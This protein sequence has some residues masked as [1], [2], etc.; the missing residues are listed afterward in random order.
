M[1]KAYES[2]PWPVY[3]KLFKVHSKERIMK[4][5]LF[6]QKYER[7]LNKAE[8]DYGVP[9]ELIVAIIGIETRYGE[10]MGKYRVIDSLATLAFDYPKR[11]H[12]FRS[13]LIEFLLLVNEQHFDAKNVY[14]SRAGALGKPQFMPSSYRNYAIDYDA[15]GQVDLFH[16]DNDAIGSIAN[17]LRR[18]GWQPR[19]PVAIP[20]TVKGD[21]YKEV[22]S[23][24]FKAVLKG[25]DL[26][27]YAITPQQKLAKNELTSLIVLG[28]KDPE[29]WLGLANFFVITRYNHSILYAMAVHQ[30][31]QE[32]ANMH[33]L[34]QK[35]HH[36]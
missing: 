31:S 25:K 7:V 32:I 35:K 22:L 34:Q 18:N 29:Y 5:H 13:E 2:K 11:S 16:D 15:S 36:G 10:R 3:K 12:F 6:W 17:F 1:N 4:G 9:A 30:L 28:D 27:H 21:A 14:G 20:A 24:D 33:K 23:D 26:R 8:E 19:H